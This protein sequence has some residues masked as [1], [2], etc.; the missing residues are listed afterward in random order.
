MKRFKYLDEV[1]IINAEEHFFSNICFVIVDE[2]ILNDEYFYT[3][4]PRGVRDELIPN[5]PVERR[6]KNLESSEEYFKK[7]KVPI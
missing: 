3:L 5:Y 4:V 2:K 7:K 1:F 6:A